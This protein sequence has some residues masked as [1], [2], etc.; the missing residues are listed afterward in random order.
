MTIGVQ[1]FQPDNSPSPLA[2]A[3]Q[4]I[5]QGV[6]AGQQM[7]NNSTRNK[8]QAPTLQAQLEEQQ[9]KNQYIPQD[10]DMELQR[11]LTAQG[12]L[13]Q[14]M[15]RFTPASALRQ[16]LNSM[17]PNARYAWI[18]Q[19]QDA[20]NAL[21]QSEAQAAQSSQRTAP[22]V[23]GK[24]LPQQQ[25]Q[26][27]QS[28]QQQMQQP[29]TQQPAGLQ[30]QLQQQSGV[31]L[32]SAVQ[33]MAQQQVP[34]QDSLQAALTNLQ[35]QNDTGVNAQGESQAQPVSV[36]VIKDP[37]SAQNEIIQRANED[38][39]NFAGLPN[40]DKKRYGA[41][42]TMDYFFKQPEVLEALYQSTKYP[43]LMGSGKKMYDYAA[44]PTEY[45]AYANGTVTLPKLFS[46]SLAGL[47]GYPTSELGL[48]SATDFLS[49]KGLSPASSREDYREA[50]FKKIGL[51]DAENKSIG[52][53]YERVF[54][55]PDEMV[56]N[57]KIARDYTKLRDDGVSQEDAIKQIMQS[58]VDAQTGK[59][60]LKAQME[61]SANASNAKITASNGKTYTRE[62]LMKIAS[63]GK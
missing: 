55:R 36:D 39:A 4:S 58:T 9:L 42:K 21:L 17:A 26:A 5:Q 3:L 18:A 2:L 6:L 35:R 23:L 11:A 41:A 63:G 61:S 38:S 54:Q 30:Q 10:K 56:S 40:Y 31:P 48:K 22:S 44:N 43:G 13:E 8:Y 16:S 49:F 57:E 28:Q 33:P 34:Q 51:I 14:S 29:M 24:Y 47:E 46:G 32:Q 12:Q 62:E 60:S 37:V 25:Q 53:E 27:P 45:N 50:L 19:N 7:K 15:N 1:Q 52:K 59:P 20:Y